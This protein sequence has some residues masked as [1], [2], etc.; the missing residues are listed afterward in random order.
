MYFNKQ[1]RLLKEQIIHYHSHYIFIPRN[2]PLRIPLQLDE[3]RVCN[4][5]VQVQVH[6][7][8]IV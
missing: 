8:R 3:Q 1:I 4:S 7:L 6:L 5:I 2:N